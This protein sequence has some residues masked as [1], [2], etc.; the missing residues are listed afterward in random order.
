MTADDLQLSAVLSATKPQGM[1]GPAKNASQATK[2][3]ED[4]EAV[5]INE[6]MGAM[7]E[8]IK[9]DGPFGGG[10]GESI[11]RSMMIDQYSKAIAKQGGFG[12]ATAVKNEL[13]H[14][15]ENAR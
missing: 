4:F 15:Q 7:F 10:P 12:L 11:F 5:F 1:L 9:T 14:A 6:F 13:L 3:A 8:G 2:A